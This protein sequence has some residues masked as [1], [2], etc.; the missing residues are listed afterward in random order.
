[1]KIGDLVTI[2]AWGSAGQ[3]G[4]RPLGF[5]TCI[6]PEEI[7]DPEEVEVL[8]TTR[9]TDYSNHSTCTLEVVSEQG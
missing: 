7:G 3:F 1:M 2:A 9:W 4:G 6:D 5:V 8:W